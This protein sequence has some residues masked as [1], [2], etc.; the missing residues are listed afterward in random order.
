MSSAPAGDAV[1]SGLSVTGWRR[2]VPHLA[3]L[4]ALSQGAAGRGIAVFVITGLLV[5]A[6]N[7]AF[8][9]LVSRLLGPSSYGALG[10]LLNITAVLAVPLSALELAIA[11]AVA[12]SAADGALPLRRSIVNAA[13]VGLVIYL[14]WLLLTDPIDRFFHLQSALATIVL[15]AVLL[16]SVVFAV[17]EG[18]LIGSK[19]FR[20]AGLGQLAGAIAKLI[21]GVGL[22]AAGSGVVSGSIATVLGS[23]VTLAWYGWVMRAQLLAPGRLHGIFRSGML[24]TVALAGCA[25]LASLDAWL[26][27]HYLDAHAAGLFVADATA[28]NIAIFLPSAILTVHFPLFAKRGEEAQRALR[29]C[30]LLVM[31]TSVAVASVFELAS[32]LVTSL[33]FGSSYQ[34]GAQALGAV[35]L[36]DVLIVTASCFVYFEVARGSLA[37]LSGWLG[38]GVAW[39]LASQFHESVMALALSMLSATA[40]LVA[41]L[42]PFT[43]VTSRR[44]LRSAIAGRSTTASPTLELPSVTG[45]ER[46]KYSTDVN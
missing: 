41:V 28:G 27:R 17:L 31:I 30:L 19:K 15:G 11:Q 42:A 24:S 38:C 37:A 39:L 12:R 40:I 29:N 4:W 7:L 26:A 16:P 6:S 46:G 25:L 22:V 43:T 34:G 45:A 21:T 35:T 10:A 23:V 3:R 5:N 33:L 13:L 44:Q 32:G 20:S 9:L 1:R 18:V 8:H 2:I 36:S 14:A